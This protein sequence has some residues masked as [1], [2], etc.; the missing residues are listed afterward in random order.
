MKGFLFGAAGWVV[1][2]PLMA[3]AAVYVPPQEDALELRRD[4]LLLDEGAMR[5]LAWDLA[6]LA[7]GLGNEGKPESLRAAAQLVAV[8]LTLDSGQKHAKEVNLDLLEKRT[9]KVGDDGSQART[10]RRVLEVVGWLESEEAGATGKTLASYLKDPLATA[11][12]EDASA[13]SAARWKG[14]VAPLEAF[15]GPKAVAE[16]PKLKSE[17]GEKTPPTV[18][19]A[20]T[21]PA[22]LKLEEVSIHV[23]FIGWEKDRGRYIGMLAKVKASVKK[24]SDAGFTFRFPTDGLSDYTSLLR[25]MRRGPGKPLAVNAVSAIHGELPESVKA[26][27][28]VGDNQRYVDDNIEVLHGAAAVLMEA[29]LSGIEPRKDAVVIGYPDAEGKWRSPQRMWERL[30]NLDEASKQGGILVVP[31]D[32]VPILEAFLVFENAEFFMKYE[33]ILASNLSEVVEVL[34]SEKKECWVSTASTNFSQIQKTAASRTNSLGVFL[35]N[36]HVRDRL[37]E[38]RIQAPR[39]ASAALLLMQGNG[40]RP[41]KTS[42]K[43]AAEEIRSRMI[44]VAYA[45]GYNASEFPGADDLQQMLDKARPELEALLPKISSEERSLYEEAAAILSSVKALIRYT[46]SDAQ[47]RNLASGREQLKADWTTFRAHL[48]TAAG[49]PTMEDTVAKEKKEDEEAQKAKEAHEKAASGG[50][51]TGR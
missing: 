50:S 6:E 28:R 21:G 41:T 36:R 10:K 46:G 33:V 4:Q 20:T 40:L 15:E 49:E 12:D 38:M 26:Q 45:H 24:D 8:A 14:L 31:S 19:P 22:Q 35:A 48:A 3:C 37:Q 23:P 27:L 34:H 17:E 2:H 39:H 11:N 44:P 51:G 5:N 1:M 18:T 16:P 42:R 30:K 13:D 43:V 25:A 29:S 7:A 47:K 32:C 9:P